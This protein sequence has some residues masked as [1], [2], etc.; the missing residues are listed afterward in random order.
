M[1]LKKSTHVRIDSDVKSLLDRNNPSDLSYSN[2]LRKKFSNEDVNNVNKNVNNDVNILNDFVN[3]DVN[4]LI[5][6]VFG[7]SLLFGLFFF[8]KLT[9][10]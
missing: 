6:A 4:I 8:S 1:A 9:W 10:R 3:I 5:A 2:L 7:F